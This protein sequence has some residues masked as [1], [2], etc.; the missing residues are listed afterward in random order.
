MWENSCKIVREQVEVN[1]LSCVHTTGLLQAGGLGGLSPPFQFWADQLTLSQRGGGTFSPPSTK[2]PLD[3]QTLRRPCTNDQSSNENFLCKNFRRPEFSHHEWIGNGLLLCTVV[4]YLFLRVVIITLQET[5][6]SK[7][8]GCRKTVK[9]NCI[10]T[11]LEKIRCFFE[12]FKN[13]YVEII[14]KFCKIDLSTFFGFRF[15]SPF[16]YGV[17]NMVYLFF[18]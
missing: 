5:L 16:K 9:L 2:S 17:A 6:L 10:L 4:N 14:S 1:F 12:N 11:C 18:P 7:K 13:F 3:F 8:L 15:C